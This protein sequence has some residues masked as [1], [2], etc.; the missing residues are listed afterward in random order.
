MGLAK[1]PCESCPY[2]KDAPSG[3][4]SAQEYDKLPLYDRETFYQPFAP[5]AC[6]A[7]PDNYCYGWVAVHMNRGHPYELLAL[8]LAACAAGEKTL[9]IPLPQVE[10]FGSGTEAAAHG[11]KKIANPPRATRARA[12]K[13]L[14]K[15][16]RLQEG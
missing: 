6:H 14:K 12:A 10:L 11:K 8:R 4:W 16:P 1:G 13:M 9:R 2:R 7:A 5:F 3:L 15:Y